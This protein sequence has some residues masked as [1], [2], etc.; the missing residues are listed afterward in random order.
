MEHRGRYTFP[1]QG[2]VKEVNIDFIELVFPNRVSLS[3]A[4]QQPGVYRL[5]AEVSTRFG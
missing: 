2:E 3:S 4:G 5:A 1:A